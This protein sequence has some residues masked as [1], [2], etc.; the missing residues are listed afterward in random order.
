MKKFGYMV[1]ITVFVM[2]FLL[3]GG[4]TSAAASVKLHEQNTMSVLWYQNSGEAKALYYQGYAIGKMQL[5]EI[6]AKGQYDKRKKPAIVLDIDE[7]ILDNSPYFAW[8]VLTGSPLN[9]SKWF[10]QAKAKPLPGAVDFLKFADKKGVAIYYISN[11]QEAQKAATIRNLKAVGAPQVNEQHVLL[12]Q[13]DE[14][15][16]ET[17]RMKVAKSHDIV[18]L[19]GDNLGDFSGFDELSVSGRVQAVERKK[20]DF[21]RKL[22]VFPNPMYGDWEGAIYQYNYKR[23][24]DELDKLRKETLQPEQP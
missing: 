16:K 11:R 19:F 8:L 6:L 14:K 12:Q 24:N 3:A 5:R 17:R 9:W 15:G 4:G 18:L 21:G 7:T 23:T 20:A 1:W 13:P 10:N 2:F 22:I